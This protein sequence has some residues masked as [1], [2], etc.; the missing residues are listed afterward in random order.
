MH[1]CTQR[2]LNSE[3]GVG[4]RGSGRNTSPIMED[5]LGLRTEDG[6][7]RSLLSS[8]RSSL[9]TLSL[10]SSARK[11]AKVN[12]YFPDDKFIRYSPDN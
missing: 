11:S 5:N 3:R 12:P 4:V 1:W 2:I 7:L 8:K 10:S 6:R 9:I